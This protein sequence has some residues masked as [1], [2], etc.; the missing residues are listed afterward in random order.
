MDERITVSDRSVGGSG[1]TVVTERGATVAHAQKGFEKPIFFSAQNSERMKDYFGAPTVKY[2]E[3]AEA[4][5]YNSYGN[6]WVSA[7]SKDGRLGAIAIPK[8]GSVI[9]YGMGL[10][11]SAIATSNFTDIMEDFKSTESIASL[12]GT[13]SSPTTGVVAESLFI[14]LADGTKLV[15]D[16]TEA[17]G[18]ETYTLVDSGQ[19]SVF[20]SAE[21]TVATGVIEVTLTDASGFADIDKIGILNDKSADF[22]SADG[23]LVVTTSTPTDIPVYI[24]TTSDASGLITLTVY[25]KVSGVTTEKDSYTFSLDPDSTDDFG[26]DNYITDI[27]TDINPFIQVYFLGDDFSAFSMQELSLQLLD[28]H[29]RGATLPA[30]ALAGGSYAK[31][32]SYYQQKNIF[33]ADIFY[34]PSDETATAGQISTVVTNFQKNT[35][36]IFAIEK[37]SATDI[38]AD[39]ISAK[40]GVTS[41]DMAA[42]DSWHVMS[43]TYGKGAI[44]R[45]LTGRIAVKYAQ[46]KDVANGLSPSYV[47]E[48]GHGGQLGA[49]VVEPLYDDRE[50]L[51]LTLDA[52]HI[53]FVGVDLNYGLMVQGDRTCASD[54]GDYSYIGRRRVRNYIADQIVSLILP[55]QINKPNDS[56]HRKKIYNQTTSVVSP[57]VGGGRGILDDALVVCDLTNNTDIIRNANTFVLDVV[58]KI[59]PNSQRIK[60]NIV[61]VDQLTDVT[62]Y[63]GG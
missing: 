13:Y 10:T 50:G 43:N 57:L 11:E 3:I 31:G 30:T 7:P 28:G 35:S 51:K 15:L 62:D 20:A 32:W 16:V 17:A 55:L 45:N 5:D 27:I 36:G 53:N 9:E 44:L 47:D 12:V 58:I 4:F 6:G 42:Y 54:E 14:Y 61:N 1:T 22:V 49:G 39:P 52:D 8:T 2:P 18:V 40:K 25:E 24:D 46:M 41:P 63:I 29:T 60:L 26:V 19:F 38:I 21:R 37:L 33:P 56:L 48:N 34:D 23:T 59:T